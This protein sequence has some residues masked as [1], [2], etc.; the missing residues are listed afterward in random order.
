MESLDQEIEDINDIGD[1][2]DSDKYDNDSNYDSEAEDEI[3]NSGDI[4]AEVK[5]NTSDRPR[6]QCTGAGVESLEMSLNNDKEYASV[7]E[8]HYQF[9][10]HSSDHPFMGGDKSFIS[11]AANYSFAQVNEHAQMLAKA[12]IKQFGDQAIAA[13]LS[14]YKKLN[15][16][17]IPD[18]PVFGCVNPNNIS[19]G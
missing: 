2:D 6:R 15:M 9:T 12:G 14:E 10:M 17:F 19:L 8:K 11:V 16:G 3:I 7:K 13:M 1:M 5:F 18:K 4:R